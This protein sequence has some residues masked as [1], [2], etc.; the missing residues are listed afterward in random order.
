MFSR[1]QDHAR[2]DFA[3]AFY[4]SKYRPTLRQVGFCLKRGGRG[5]PPGYGALSPERTR[6]LIGRAKTRRDDE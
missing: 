3:L 1:A 6:Q 2:Q 4:E 5:H